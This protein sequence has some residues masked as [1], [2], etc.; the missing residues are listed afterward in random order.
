[1]GWL[2][3]GASNLP[4]G[5]WG[6]NEEQQKSS[7]H[8]PSPSSSVFSSPQIPCPGAAGPL[9]R[10]QVHCPRRPGCG[11]CHAARSVQEVSPLVSSLP[12][13]LCEEKLPSGPA[14]QELTRDGLFCVP[15]PFLG[16]SASSVAPSSAA[17]TGQ[18]VLADNSGSIGCPCNEQ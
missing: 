5:K 16:P 17:P 8:P 18:G 14:G 7:I 3:D 9:G 6:S 13:S 11:P 1:M 15:C 4:G 12:Q 10:P 2:G